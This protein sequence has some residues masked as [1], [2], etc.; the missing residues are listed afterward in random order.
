MLCIRARISTHARKR[1]L[2]IALA[3]KKRPWLDGLLSNADA[4][5]APFTQFSKA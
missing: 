5:A 1:I 4:I 2:R 3:P